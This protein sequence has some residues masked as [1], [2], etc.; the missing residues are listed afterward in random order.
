M[1]RSLFFVA[2]VFASVNVVQA[3]HPFYAGYRWTSNPS[4]H[5][6]PDNQIQYPA[7]VIQDMRVQELHFGSTPM[8]IMYHTVHVIIHVNDDAGIEKYNKVY[9]PL[10]G[11]RIL[12][13]LSVRSIAPD[14]KVTVFNQANLKELKNVEGYGNFKIFA[15]EGLVK[16]GELEYVY[17][18]QTSAQTLGSETFQREIPVKE[19]V[20]QLIYPERFEFSTKS[21]NGFNIG[22]EV[23]YDAKRM[24]I[25]ASHFDIPAL[26]EE[27]YSS[28]R[29][30]LMR[31]DYCLSKTSGNSGGGVSWGS[32]FKNILNN[33]LDAKGQGRLSKLIEEI[34]VEGLT[35]EEQVTK[36]EKYIKTHFTIKESHEE[37][38]E[39]IK[40]ILSTRVANDRGILKVYV[41]IFGQLSIHSQIVF[42]CER[43][44]GSFDVSFPSTQYIRQQL[45]YFPDLK[46]YLVPDNSSLRLG[47]APESIAESN[48]CFISYYVDGSSIVYVSSLFKSI[49]SLPDTMNDLGVN[50]LIQFDPSLKSLQVEQEN[51]WQ[52]YRAAELRGYYI[53]RDQQ[54]EKD[55][56]FN[57]VTLSGIENYKVVSR[58]IEGENVNLSGDPEQYLRVNTKYT[59]SSLFEKAGDDYLLSACKVIGKQSELYQEGGER[60]T[61]VVFH[62]ISS[63]KHTITVKIPEGYT[64]SGLEA[65]KIHN[66]VIDNGV[67]VMYFDSDYILNGDTLTITAVEV[68]KKLMLPKSAY[69]SFRKVINSASDFSK[70][71]IV[72]RPKQ[73]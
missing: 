41:G 18:I 10:Y 52:G 35:S 70:V 48:A 16:G 49:E 5:S 13:S 68:Y 28:Y 57:T 2:L 11:S 47:A 39:N 25:H 30:N 62:G 60:F 46:A 33:S 73:S 31:I 38:Y 64:C 54:A 37:S 71:T 21:Y 42:A 66:E 20:F 17:T 7:V 67:R 15:I 29:D 50:A 26:P 45:F 55:D 32:L 69:E 14:N 22:D 53:T 51:R 36:I 43:S 40:D 23:G 44:R 34:G 3:E 24:N 56:F 6:V 65:L 12:Q 63:Y 58:K 72:F 4:I 61:D 1:I 8:P 19:A 27:A 59:V 9:L